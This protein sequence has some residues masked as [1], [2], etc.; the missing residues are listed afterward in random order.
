MIADVAGSSRLMERNESQT[1]ERLRRIR[2]EVTFPKIEEYGG[3]VVKTT[4][5]GFLAEFGSAIA[6]VRCGIEIQRKVI[7]LEASQADVD[8]IHFRIGLNVG[9]I[10]VDGEDVAG[11]GVN[12]A[13]R[14]ET[15][16]PLDGMCLSSSVREQIRDDLG[17]GFEDMGEQTLKNI[18]RAVRVYAVRFRS[19]VAQAEQQAPPQSAVTPDPSLYQLIEIDTDFDA[20]LG[21]GGSASQERAKVSTGAD[22]KEQKDAADKA[23]R[24]AAAMASTDAHAIASLE[25]QAEA[26]RGEEERRR[27]DEQAQER[28]RAQDQAREESAR[29][30]R[31]RVAARARFGAQHEE[32]ER[33]FAEMEKELEAAQAAKVEQKRPSDSRWAWRKRDKD[34]ASERVRAE[35]AVHANE[36]EVA[37]EETPVGY[38]TPI[39]WGKPVALGVFLI[40]LLG[41]VLV[42]VVSFEGYIPQFEKLA[43]AQLR[44]PVKIK[45][46]HLSL[47]PPAHWRLDGVSVG[48][49]GQLTVAR[50]NAAAELGSMFSDKK[51]FKSIELESPALSEQGLFALLFGKPQGQNLKVASIIVKNGKL[52]LNTMI[53][54]AVDAKIAMGEDGT[55]QKI[56][57]ETPDHKTSVLLE[58]KGEGAQLEVDT[59]AFKMPFGPAFILKD[60][61]AAGV[62]GRDELRLS[63][64]KGGIYDG[65]VSGTA[66]LKWGAGWSLSGEINARA[67]DPN[68]ITPALLE[69]GKLE[70]KAT[71]AMRAKSYDELFAAPRM[72]GSFAVR[73]GSL[74]GVDL[75]RLLQG[76]GVGGRTVFAELSGDFVLEGGETRLRQVHL[77]AGPVSA[78]GNAGADASKN[79]SGRFAVEFKSPVAQARA[80]LALSGTLREPRFTR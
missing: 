78:G 43:S 55:W 23:L 15:L 70:G 62:L 10:I 79:L 67:M 39:N 52:N 13:A 76:G 63:E 56:A 40:V 44:Q 30:E 17:V 25:A 53:L 16:S 41:L 69:E 45:A 20:V 73:K 38:H 21:A 4:G 65:Y 26:K 72:E 2:E 75:A 80:D 50:I 42:H 71:Y 8:R 6:A 48:N 29:L 19:A 47:L 51:V 12:I 54:P 66:N 74:L 33:H 35:A 60:F 64:F 27:K 18:S 34:E 49:E 22:E 59:N 37:I 28:L 1:F 36:A 14:L 9:D 3:R 11:D 32:T 46:L 68:L 61:S 58:P 77:R 24:D 31:E 7:E 57:L 5:D